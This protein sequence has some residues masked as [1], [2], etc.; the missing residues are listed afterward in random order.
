MAHIPQIPRPDRPGEGRHEPFGSGA[1]PAREA[2]AR[3]PALMLPGAIIALLVVLVGIE[4]L[5]GQL[6]WQDDLTVLGTF[7]FIPARYADR[8]GMFPG[9][10]GADVWTFVTYAL[11]HGGWM[12]L[13][14]NS[15]WLLAFGSAV[16]RR[17]GA[18][19][20]FAFFAVTAAA[21]AAVQLALHFGEPTPVVGAS[22]AIA[23]LMA[24]AARFV[25][26][27]RGPLTVGS[28][29]DMSAFRR[30]ARSL[31]ETLRNPR[32]LFFVLMFF[33]I[34]LLIGVGSTLAGGIS[35]AWEAH[36]GGFLAGLLLF[37]VFDP[38][39]ARPFPEQ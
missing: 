7:A 35:I 22:A 18:L 29:G 12:H 34:N 4:A 6:S 27:G 19:R 23:G 9:G 38:V 3:E 15:V 5:R 37:R 33:G 30:P 31:W 32:A 39:S 2:Q 28:G 16:A 21:G 17:F 13:V 36:I 14:T 26:D 25:F 8:F 1:E 24:A 10:I 11:L 20:F